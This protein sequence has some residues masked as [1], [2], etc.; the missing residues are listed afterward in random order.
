[1]TSVSYSRGL[2]NAAQAKT[3]VKQKVKADKQ[4]ISVSRSEHALYAF[5][6]IPAAAVAIKG[7]SHMI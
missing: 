6:T 4:K 5:Q 2:A 1:M 3:D 7:Q